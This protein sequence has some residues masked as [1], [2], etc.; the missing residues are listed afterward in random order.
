M[1]KRTNNYT[2]TLVEHTFEGD[3]LKHLWLSDPAEMRRLFYAS[4]AEEKV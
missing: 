1:P 3:D 4:L 2:P